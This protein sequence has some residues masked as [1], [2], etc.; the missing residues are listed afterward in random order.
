[1][2]DDDTSLRPFSVRDAAGC[3][4]RAPLRS[5]HQQEDA[6]IIGRIEPVHGTEPHLGNFPSHLSASPRLHPYGCVVE[7]TR[8]A[9]EVDN[10]LEVPDRK[11]SRRLFADLTL[12]LAPHVTDDLRYATNAAMPMTGA[13]GGFAPKLPKNGFSEKL[14]TPPSDATIR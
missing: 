7:Q 5:G 4:S 14:K 1:M 6:V 13:A 9:C 12:L 11:H 8:R 2:L 10:L 3:I